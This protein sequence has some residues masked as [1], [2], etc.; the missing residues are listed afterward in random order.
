ME[1]QI[2]VL[3]NCY[4][5]ALIKNADGEMDNEEKRIIISSM[6]PEF[7]EFDGTRHRTQRIN[8]VLQLIYQNTNKLTGKRRDKSFFF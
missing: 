8:G 4:Q 1:Q 7:L 2:N 5:N 6:F 3:N